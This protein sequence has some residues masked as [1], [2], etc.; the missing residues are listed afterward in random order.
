MRNLKIFILFFLIFVTNCGYEPIYS[1]KNIQSNE[2]SLIQVKNIK[3]R[4]GQILR[5][6]LI[7]IFNSADQKKRP[8]YLLEVNLTEGIQE[9]GYR[10]DLSATR[11][12]LS[13]TADYRLKNIKKEEIIYKGQALAISS[14]DIVE[15]LYATMIAE[16]DARNKG[17][18]IITDTIA[19]DLAIF[20]NNK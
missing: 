20:F 15:S 10:K 14:Y 16:K 1:K 12:N 4:P 18:K 3:D 6:N 8:R 7:D 11:S 9:I 13:I 19:T 5:N 17:L 2:L